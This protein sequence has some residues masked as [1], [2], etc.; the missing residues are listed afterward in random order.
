VALSLLTTAL[1]MKISYV[2]NA[3]QS[4]LSEKNK[5]A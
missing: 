1:L 4:A 5:G 3:F 2:Q